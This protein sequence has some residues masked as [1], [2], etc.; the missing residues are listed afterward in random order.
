MNWEK[1]LANNV[2]AISGEGG[3][4]SHLKMTESEMKKLEKITAIWPLSV[5]RYYL[6][7]VDSND[8]DDPIRRMCV[9]S[10]AEF[11]LDGAL[12]TSG[13]EQNTKFEGLQHKYGPTGLMLSTNSCAMYCRYCFRKRLVGLKQDEVAKFYDSIFDYISKHKE[14]DNLLISGGD[15]LL[16]S[17][18]DLDRMLTLA[19]GCGNLDFVRL[20]T[21]VPVVFPMRITEDRELVDRLGQHC[22]RKR[23]YIVTHYNH[24]RELTEESMRAISILQNAGL[25]LNNQTV[26]LRGVND[27]AKTMTELMKRLTVAGIMPYYVFQCRPVK[28][29]K[30]QFQVPFRRGHEIIEHSKRHLNGM[31]KRFRFCLSHETG[32]IEILGPVNDESFAFKYHQ[33]KKHAD[34][35]RLFTMNISEQDAWLGS[36]PQGSGRTA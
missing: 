32:K 5:P 3:L 10:S 17:N 33:A 15:A 27:N 22:R 14:I 18:N 12:D 6:S 28:G 34:N 20:G 1:E 26:L 30:N 31:A 36:I 2:T 23:I 24:P 29:V 9:P 25:A 35:G 13:E 21:R 16:N 4:C 11:D 7:L 19:E 8:P